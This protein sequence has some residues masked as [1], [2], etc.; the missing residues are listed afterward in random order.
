MTTTLDSL[1]PV[2]PAA[3]GEAPPRPHPTWRPSLP[4]RFARLL[5]VLPPA[6]GLGL[7]LLA[8]IVLDRA[9]RQIT[10]AEL[11]AEIAA[12]GDLR[13]LLALGFTLVSF[14]ALAGYE[15]FA[16]RYVAKPLP[17][18]RTSLVAFIAQSIAHS[19]GFAAFVGVGL[20]YRIYSR[21]GIGV[22]DI[23]RIQ[24]FFSWTF[25]LGVLTLSGAALL[26]EPTV[27]TT[28]VG[29]PTA[30]WQAAG[31]LLLLAV[32]AY[33]GASALT[34]S[35][36]I[37]V[38]GH[39][40]ALPP[41][42]T[43]ALQIGLAV[44]DLGAA[45]AALYVLLPD[46]G[47]GFFAFTGLFT[48]A[49]MVGVLSHVPGALGVF[50]SLL[51]LM[52]QPAP[53]QLPAMLGA[54]VLFRVVYYVLP[55]LVGV[56]LLGW[57]EW[58]Q[59][60]G[61]VRAAI[62]GGVRAASLIAPR[63]FAIMAFVGGL[64]LLISGVLPAEAER[65][66]RLGTLLPQPVIELSHLTG[67]LIGVALLILARGLDHRIA[68][69]WSL[70]VS[71][72]AVGIVVS[73]LKG[74]DY[75]EAIVLA[76]TLVALVASRPEFY[77][78]A[79]LL[80]ERP[81]LAWWIGVGA[82]FLG[83]LWLI[84]FSYRH[85]EYA[86]ELWWQVELQADAPRALRAALAS[87]LILSAYGAWQ[88]LKPARARP[89]LPTAAELDQ[90]Q[91]IVAHGSSNTDWLAL[92]GDKALLFNARRDAFI[93]YGVIGRSWVAMGEP[94]GPQ[95]AWSE[96][97]WAFHEKANR[98]GARTVFYEVPARALP[99]YLDLGLTMLKL[100]E[101]AT[102]ELAG[103]GLQGRQRA[104]LRHGHN[105]AKH[106]GASFEV[107]PP[108]EVVREI[109]RLQAVSDA[110]L[111]SHK[112]R[113]KRFSLGFFDPT[114][115]ARTPVAVVRRNQEIVAF[116]TLWLAGNK[117][118][119]SPDLMR[120]GPAAPKGVMDFLMIEIMLWARAQGFRLC[121]LGM[122]P[123]SGLSAHRLAP[124]SSKFGRLLYRH[125]ANFYNFEGLRAFKDKFDP[126]WEPVYL[127]YPRGSLARVLADVASLVAGGWMGVIA[128]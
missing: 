19:T 30:F 27:G 84:E 16:L 100:G 98:R 22:T 17:W 29:L 31:V 68:E 121:D 10:Y 83:V 117:S 54:L 42:G 56:G 128:K 79:S 125:G 45:A 85:V 49:I 99:H 1:N 92:A 48:V 65:L 7:L 110:W 106:E 46:L 3:V 9:F 59:T 36:K 21:Y 35:I 71:L 6:L 24:L 82:T 108:A 20:R 67:S 91:V 26:L 47:I 103:F 80:D 88:L 64:V 57:F 74:F 2:P 116:A 4:G 122:A 50:E 39:Q 25:S 70:T 62:G 40:L 86:N 113:E 124:L 69:A 127:I 95:A 96:L 120:Y 60:G 115:V 93:M 63:L 8:V 104:S 90:A 102:V 101:S 72:L 66:A 76:V 107:L 118:S 11:S 81:S 111:A 5:H 61:P 126:A 97:I 89:T 94:V 13:I 123:L 73:L 18:L 38:L 28:V 44:V 109:D 77:R 51:L 23:A 15:H 43:T 53:E 55:L 114:F 12:L 37:V 41:P 87:A 33:L 75:E 34:R 112:T 78:H 14:I 58:R 32:A 119:C 105:H 52:L